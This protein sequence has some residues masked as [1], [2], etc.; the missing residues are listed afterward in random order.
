MYFD[1]LDKGLSETFSLF[2]YSY[3]YFLKMMHV[4]NIIH[5]II[6][7]NMHIK[8]KDILIKLQK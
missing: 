6:H 1:I 5:H 8:E 7:H 2:Q 4:T 3:I